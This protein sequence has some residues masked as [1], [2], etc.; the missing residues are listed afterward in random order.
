MLSLLLLWS[1]PFRWN[2]LNQRDIKSVK[3]LNY[4]RHFL[5]QIFYLLTPHWTI[6]SLC[7]VHRNIRLN[8]LLPGINL[9][10]IPCLCHLRQVLVLHLLPLPLL[11]LIS[12]WLPLLQCLI[13]HHY[14]LLYVNL[15]L[16]YLLILSSFHRVL[17]LLPERLRDHIL[18]FLLLSLACLNRYPILIAFILTEIWVIILYLVLLLCDWLLAVCYPQLVIHFLYLEVGVMMR[19]WVH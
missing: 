10:G 7:R 12:L 16:L 14:Q 19:V 17:L 13:A 9:Y 15:L 1:L 8:T 11:I 5:N 3:V 18:I 2:L 4:V 6:G